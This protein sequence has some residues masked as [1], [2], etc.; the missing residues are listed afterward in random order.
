MAGGSRTS[1]DARASRPRRGFAYSVGEWMRAILRNGFAGLGR[2][3]GERR[4]ELVETLQLGGKRQLM[5]VMCDGRP[6]LVGGG[7]DS[8]HSI[9]E[10]VPQ[11]AVATEPSAVSSG[12]G[13]YETAAVVHGTGQQWRFS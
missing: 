13:A 3:G 7:G 5:L 10:M 8:V 2:A 4:M 9:A 6:Y 11:S 1:R 12:P